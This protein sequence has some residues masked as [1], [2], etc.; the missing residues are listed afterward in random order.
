MTL[1]VKVAAVMAG[2]AQGIVDLVSS[3]AGEGEGVGALALGALGDLSKANHVGIQK[4]E[5][6]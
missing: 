5:P 3:V 6:R 4:R 1:Q 2:Q